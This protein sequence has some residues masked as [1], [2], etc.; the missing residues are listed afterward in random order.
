MGLITPG[1]DPK[2]L[3]NP[4]LTPAYWGASSKILD[5]ND[6]RFTL[7]EGSTSTT[8]V[9]FTT[10][11]NIEHPCIPTVIDKNKIIV[12]TESA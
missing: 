12:P 10:Y 1:S 6:I 11:R 4:M 8:A 9:M 7:L 5:L 3:D 2:V